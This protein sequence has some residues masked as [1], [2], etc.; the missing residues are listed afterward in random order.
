[1]SVAKDLRSALGQRCKFLAA[2]VIRVVQ[3]TAPWEQMTFT[4][5]SLVGDGHPM[6]TPCFVQGG[7]FLKCQQTLMLAAPDIHE[8]CHCPAIL[9]WLFSS[10]VMII[11]SMTYSPSQMV[12]KLHFKS[13]TGPHDY[14]S[15]LN[16]TVY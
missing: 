12:R 1:M 16:N 8:T 3:G 15:W 4:G 11:C 9:Q 2:A 14:A 10:S 5:L 6:G 13:H 7:T